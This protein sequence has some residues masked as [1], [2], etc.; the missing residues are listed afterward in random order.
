MEIFV[1]LNRE[2]SLVPTETSIWVKSE[3]ISSDKNVRKLI[4]SVHET[5]TS[6]TQ[7]KC[8]PRKKD[9]SHKTNLSI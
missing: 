6:F 1:Q 8:R 7:N 9:F 3:E 4:K 5:E 2:R